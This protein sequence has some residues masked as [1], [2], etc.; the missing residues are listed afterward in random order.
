VAC[1]PR[2]ANAP[3][4]GQAEGVGDCKFFIAELSY[5]YNQDLTRYTGAC[6]RDL[7]GG[8]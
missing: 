1:S 4:P 5:I 8:R 3:V 7:Q 6:I 2:P